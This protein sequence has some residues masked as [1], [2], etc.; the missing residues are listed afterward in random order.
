MRKKTEVTMD[1][2]R[3]RVRVAGVLEEDGKLLL[4]KKKK[5]ERSNLRLPGGGVDWGESLEEAVK[6]EFL[7]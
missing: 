3:P 4:I 2:N 7:E 6:R 1:N 5:N